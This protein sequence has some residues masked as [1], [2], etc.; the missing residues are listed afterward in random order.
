MDLKELRT[1]V[2]RKCVLRVV[3][4]DAHAKAGSR[5]QA[6]QPGLPETLGGT[7]LGSSQ[8]SVEMGLHA[9]LSGAERA[10]FLRLGSAQRA[11]YG[12]DLPER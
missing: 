8:V 7:G 5:L 11:T 6:A 9:W 12:Q 2:S 3:E 4:Q 10:L 1:L